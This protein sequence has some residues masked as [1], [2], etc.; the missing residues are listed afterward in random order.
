M[1]FGARLLAFLKFGT[2]VFYGGL[3]TLT[4]AHSMVPYRYQLSEQL[5]LSFLMQRLQLYIIELNFTHLDISL[6]LLLTEKKETGGVT[7]TTMT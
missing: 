1:F 6:F 5:I 7:G 4:K 3:C 2:P